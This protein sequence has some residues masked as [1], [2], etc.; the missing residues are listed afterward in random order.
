MGEK[1]VI[2]TIKKGNRRKMKD[3]YGREIDYLRISITDRCN[4][5]CSHC[6][7]YEIKPAAHEDILR[8]EE[9]LQVC[10]ACVKLGIH[11][12]KITGGEPLLRKAAV[13]FIS[14]L[15]A[16]EGVRTVTLTTNG[17]LLKEQVPALKQAGIDAVNI[18]LHALNPIEYQQITGFDYRERTL[19]GLYE[20]LEAGIRTKLNCVLLKGKEESAM[21]VVALAEKLP[22]DVRLIE[23]M[24]VGCG[25]E[26]EG[27]SAEQIGELL[28]RKYPD[29]HEEEG[30]VGNGPARYLVSSSLKGR[31]G[32]IY[33]VSQPFC[34]SCNRVR[35]TSI[36]MLKPC[37]CYG[38]ATDLRE[39]LRNPL[40]TEDTLQRVI[41]QTI[42]Q[43]P[44]RHCFHEQSQI[45][46]N[47]KMVEIGG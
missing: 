38:E 4:L 33:A 8:Y 39:V 27:L 17:V 11:H 28:Y 37:L 40:T 1:A 7:P 6:M 9:I 44:K 25:K 13:N 14:T 19:E 32:R 21:E 46:E 36:G 43:K 35:L 24:P 42:Y 18:S 16:M 22:V 2:F 10:K 45:S 47:R 23:L 31:V 15:K 20:C 29:L 5:R 26:Q 3:R 41:Q 30:R 34:E 12:F